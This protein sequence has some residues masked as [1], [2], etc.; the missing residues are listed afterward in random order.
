[1]ELGRRGRKRQLAVEDEYW[2]LIL[3]GVGTVDACRQVG[4]GR[5]TGYRWRAE[6]GVCRR[7]D[8]TRPSAKVGTCHSWK[9]SG[10]QPC[11]PKGWAFGRSPSAWGVLHRRLVESCAAT[12]AHMTEVCMTV[13]SRMPELDK[14]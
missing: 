13:T 6:R 9:G 5:K 1:M 12:S 10:S 11:A 2:K 14:L 3:A 8:W 4:I 7:C